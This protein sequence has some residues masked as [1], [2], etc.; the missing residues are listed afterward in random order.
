[1]IAGSPILRYGTLIRLV[2]PPDRIDAM[3]RAMLAGRV[4]AEASE[5]RATLNGKENGPG[6]V[7]SAVTG[8]NRPFR[9]CAL[10]ALNRKRPQ[11]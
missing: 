1:M 7:T 9:V 5:E 4:E 6:V 10:R 3:A 2:V 11:R 8:A